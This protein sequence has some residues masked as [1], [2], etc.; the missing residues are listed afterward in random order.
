MSKTI[1]IELSKADYEKLLIF[2]S[3]TGCTPEKY[4]S[5]FVG[6]LLNMRSD[7]K[8]TKGTFMKKK[9]MSDKR[10]FKS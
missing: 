9:I 1:T 10:S 8:I 2:S 4:A 7:G 6:V 5:I 3:D